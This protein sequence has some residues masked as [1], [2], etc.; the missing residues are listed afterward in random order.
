[1]TAM[2]RTPST[3]PRR[4][5]PRARVLL[6][7]IASLA[8]L[9]MGPAVA[10]DGP[11]PRASASP[12]GSTLHLSNGGFA[13]GELRPSGPPATIRWQAAALVDPLD[14]DLPSV[15]AVHFPAPEK[16][17]RPDAEYC[18]ELAGGDVLFGGLAALDGGEAVLDVPRVGRLRVRRSAIARMYRWKSGGD[19]V[20]LGPNGLDGW[21]QTA[22]GKTWKEEQGQPVTD[23]EGAAIRGDLQLPARSSVEF[24]LS[25]KTKPDFI[26]ALGVGD[27]EKSV[28]RA[29]RFEVWERDLIIQRETEQE[30]DV[31]SVGEIAPGQGR[32]HLTAYLDQEK[33][34]ILVFSPDGKQLADL[35][36]AGA[37]PQVLG[38][39]SLVNKRGD[40]RLERIRVGRWN[41]EPPKPVEG[42]RSR[43]HQVDGSILYGQVAR[44]DAA[45]RSFVVGAGKD[46]SRIPEG[47]IAAV[48]LSRPEGAGDRKLA[49]VYQDGGRFSG[50]LDAIEASTLRLRVPGIEGAVTLP[51]AGLRSLVS[52]QPRAVPASVGG[53]A[54]ILELDDL[55]LP[56][57]LVDGKERPGASCLAWRPQGSAGASALRPGVAGRIVYREAPAQRPATARTAPAPP[58]GPGGVVAGFLNALGGT[59]QSSSSGGKRKSLYLRSGDVIPSE[60]TSI[61]ENGVRFKTSMSASTFVPNEKVKAVELAIPGDF[62]IKVTKSK[63]ERL[64]T[65]PRMQKENPPTHLIRSRNGDFI[66]G[67]VVGMDSKVLH[68]ELRLEPRD[69][70]R[71]RIG[72]IVWLHPEDAR[73]KPEDAKPKADAGANPA[74]AAGPPPPAPA[75]AAAPPSTAG[76]RVQ[77]VCNDGIR[78]TFVAESFAGTAIAGKSG[79]LGPCNVDLKEVD[80]LLIGG[81]IEKAAAS[82]AYQQYRLVDAVE[83]KASQGTASDPSAGATGTEGSLVGKPAP[84]FELALLDGTKF[85]PAQHRGSVLVLDFWAT[86]CGPCIQAMPQVE[87]VADEF[88]DRG[89]KLVAVNLQEEPKQIKALLERQKLHPAVALDRDG[90]VAEKYAANAIPQTVIIDREG[91]VARLFIGGG[92]HFDVM[93]REALRSVVGEAPAAP[94]SK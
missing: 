2:S 12:P 87:K 39:V 70:P 56:G 47:K 74:P 86:W 65:L 79:V 18:F 41:G 22:Q 23:Q 53:V 45:S 76:T 89:V 20:Y 49:A 52:L 93:L 42:D 11:A 66:R 60:V 68:L 59:P 71:D 48:F 85:S 19:L 73:P 72:L 34:R 80:E 21:K 33:G 7:A 91:K 35:K 6:A 50:E 61:D 94:V 30:A 4:I 14:F 1:M 88:K 78:L 36:V 9:P 92:P 64:L 16:L 26:L 81:G 43:I 44:L 32:V 75:S 84:D 38:A 8:A 10:A 37:Q 13:R 15:N 29:F 28:Q 40:V 63:R 77:A 31:A 46:E 55:R 67:R 90:A 25:W 27:D 5:R 17:P 54:G 83:P 3:R 51:L 58:P 24:E 62:P 82:L 57:R 69:I